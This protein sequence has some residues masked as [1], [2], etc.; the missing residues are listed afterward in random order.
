MHRIGAL[1][2]GQVAEAAALAEHEAALA[3]VWRSLIARTLCGSKKKSPARRRR[4]LALHHEARLHRRGGSLADAVKQVEV[5]FVAVLGAVRQQYLAVLPHRAEPERGDDAAIGVAPGVTVVQH[6]ARSCCRCRQRSRHANI[7][8]FGAPETSDDVEEMDL[9]L[10]ALIE[11]TSMGL[12]GVVAPL[13]DVGGLVADRVLLIVR[14]GVAPS[15][16]HFTARGLPELH[17]SLN[18]LADFT[19]AQ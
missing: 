15:A 17:T 3:A 18:F 4:P 5:N 12:T 8:A 10:L 16:L 6:V 13:I 19:P 2:A 1:P 14:R 9:A 7:A 11:E